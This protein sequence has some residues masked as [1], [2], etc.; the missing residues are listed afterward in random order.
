MGPAKSLPDLIAVG[1][2]RTADRTDLPDPRRL[3][4]ESNPA[5]VCDRICRYLREGQVF[6]AYFGFSS[7][8]FECGVSF[9]EMGT[10][11]LTDGV[12]VWP[13]GLHHYVRHHTLRLPEEFVETMRESGWRV[14]GPLPL[15]GGELRPDGSI[16]LP[17]TY[18]FWID[19]ARQQG[20][21]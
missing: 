9:G 3:A 7:C 1:Y 5:A 19:W 11:D 21:A 4:G 16:R 12:W 6:M 13:E 18:D 20:G 8:R 2:W 17:V 15:R 10:C 14:R